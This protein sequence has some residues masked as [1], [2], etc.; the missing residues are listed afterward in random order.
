MIVYLIMLVLSI[1]FLLLAERTEKKKLKILYYILSALP[2]FLVS[3]FRYDVGTDYITRYTYDFNT[4]VKGTDIPNLE[5]GFKTMVQIIIFFTTDPLPVFV[6]SSA[7]IVGLVMATIFTK[8][9]NM[10]LSILIFFIGGFYF[11]SLNI[12]R[13]YISISIILFAYRFLLKERKQKIYYIIAVLIAT[14]FHSTSIIMLILVFLDK[15]MLAN[16]KFVL[17][18]AA[19]ILILNQRLFD[20]IGL[21][22]QNTRF[23]VYLTGKLSV[24]D[25]SIVLIFENIVLY[26]MMYYIYYKNKKKDNIQKEDIL[27]L[28]IEGITLLVI[29]LG[30]VHMLF[31]RIAFYFSMFQILSVPYYLSK[32]DGKELVEDIKKITKNKVN[33]VK[34]ESKM[35]AI[36]TILVMSIFTVHFIR[37]YIFKD[38]NE[39]TP[40]KTVFAKDFEIK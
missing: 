25:V 26:L 29:A 22:I 39:V 33:L 13:Q 32:L 34:I 5:I 27:F 4:M 36:V 9:K 28:N 8:S 40:Y 24:G 15:K 38:T 16:I 18:V 14:T 12:M 7:I 20:I 19:I 17:P 37:S 11:D 35:V 21:F 10:V 30:S 3:A 23:N 6:I 1:L 2:F 31:L